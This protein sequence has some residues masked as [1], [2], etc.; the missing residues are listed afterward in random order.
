MHNRTPD[1][2][3]H[4]WEAVDH[5]GRSAP[6]IVDHI[7]KS[8]FPNTTD[9]AES[10]GASRM[11]RNGCISEVKRVL[12]KRGNADDQVDFREIN[13]TFLPLVRS[14]QRPSYF[15][16]ERDE[17]VP[18]RELIADPA[19]LDA[20]RR[21]MR[22]KGMECLDEADRLDRL[23]EAVMGEG[24]AAVVLPVGVVSYAEQGELPR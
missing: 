8:L 23:Y 6:R 13:S 11:L 9:A 17:E 14:L 2:A 19:Q 22:L 7:L 5:V 10:E 15:V 16:P 18:V 3:H 20:A 12:H 24:D 4:V 1:F 21:F